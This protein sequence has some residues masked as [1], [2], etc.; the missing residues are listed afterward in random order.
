MTQLVA[1]A[2]SGAFLD[3]GVVLALV[4]LVVL[5]VGDRCARLGEVLERHPALGPLA[6]G[7]LGVSPG[8]S[9]ALLLV[10]LYARGRVS[11]GTMVA[12]LLATTG[13][14]A[15]ALF[16]GAPRTAVLVNTITFVTGVTV[17]LLVDA[18]RLRGLLRPDPR[19]EVGEP[20]VAADAT[21]PA[22]AGGALP[23]TAP[24]VL[25]A[26]APTLARPARAALLLPVV[27]AFWL[28]TGAGAA[29]ALGVQ[30]PPS[31]ADPV[32]GGV[33]QLAGLLGFAA[34]VVLVLRARQGVPAEPRGRGV[35]GV[36]GLLDR[37]AT[38]A[39][40]IVLWVGAAYV[41]LAV[42]EA[43]LGPGA[44]AL[45][46]TGATAVLVGTLV[47]AVPGCGLQIAWV[48]LYLDGAV[49]L[50]G[51]LANALAQDGD[52]LLPLLFIQRRAAIGLTV[53]TT[54][55]ALLLGGLAVVL[56]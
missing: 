42:V 31:T 29:W 5:A 21:V 35:S 16:A 9:G 28:S 37:S 2:A 12:T 13:D 7:L 49:D 53:L 6:G 22:G 36:V 38:Q 43:L 52:A 1:T 23:S 19:A 3:V 8:C 45:H 47:G 24:G 56:T 51:L 50:P 34:C 18:S 39:A 27:V 15:W 32:T 17:G 20:G 30:A 40:G 55:P 46:L 33:R 4:A 44:D 25:L 11:P 14:S 54:A 41:A 26:R 48:G 10:P